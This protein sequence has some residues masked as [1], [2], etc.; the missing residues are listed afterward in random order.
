MLPVAAMTQE[1]DDRGIVKELAAA[2]STQAQVANRIWLALMTVVVVAVLPRVSPADGGRKVPL[3]L[4]LGDVDSVWFDVFIFALLVILTIAFASAH[5]QQTRAVELARRRLDSLARG[6]DANTKERPD[7]IHPRELFDMLRLPSV[8]R[9]A[10]L[11]QSS[12]GLY[13]FYATSDR[14]PGWLRI[15]SAAYYGLLKLASL[16]VYLGV[17]AW[18]LWEVHSRMT[19]NRTASLIAA[20]G[21][22]LALVT[23]VQMFLT[24]GWY[25]LQTLRKIGAGR[26]ASSCVGSGTSVTKQSGDMGDKLTP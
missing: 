11:A 18:A 16:I 19:L 4:G 3:P 25:S 22:I 21:G 13:Q 26:S 12:R 9:V 20:S 24:E 23:L 10:P 1:S 6:W 17:P 2:V 8:N 5:A 7:E 14:C 15:A